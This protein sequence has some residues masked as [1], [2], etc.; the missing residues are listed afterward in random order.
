M[1]TVMRKHGLEEPYERLKE[2]TRGRR[3]DA[4]SFNELLGRLN[5]PPAALEAL[6]GLTPA[7]YTG[8][9]EQLAKKR[10]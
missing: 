6:S 2:A 3:L 7:A 9:A 10:N 4:A 1:Q 8:L 5:L